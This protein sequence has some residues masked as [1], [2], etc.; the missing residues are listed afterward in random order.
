[1]RRAHDSSR[2]RPAGYH[3]A[4]KKLAAAGENAPLA[5]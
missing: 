3:D 2:I 4:A 5:R 1:M